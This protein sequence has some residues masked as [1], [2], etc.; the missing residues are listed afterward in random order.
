MSRGHRE[1]G[2]QLAHERVLGHD[3]LAHQSLS[4]EVREVDDRE[5]R[6]QDRAVAH[7]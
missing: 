7:C 3:E 2:E 5:R 1:V 4:D 6:L